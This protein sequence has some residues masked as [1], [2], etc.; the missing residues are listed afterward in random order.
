VFGVVALQF[1]LFHD[2][3]AA[4]GQTSN[5]PTAVQRPAYEWMRFTEDWSV[6]RGKDLSRTDDFWDRVKFISLNANGSVWL[7]L[8]GQ[9]RERAEYYRN[10]LFGASEPAQSDA[11]LLS[12]FRLSADLHVTDGLASHFFPGDFI[13]ETGPHKESDFVYA[14]I[15][16]TF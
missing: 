5:A 1:F 4:Y 12:R 9:L 6:L 7:S 2:V 8:G 14:A 13:R 16:Y 10:F 15:R 11:Y 3:R